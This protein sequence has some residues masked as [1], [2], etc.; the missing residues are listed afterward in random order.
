[1]LKSN[2]GLAI[3]KLAQL[4]T[5]KK[6]LLFLIIENASLATYPDTCAACMMCTTIAYAS[7]ALDSSLILSRVKPTTLKLV[8]T[9][10]LLD[11]QQALKGQ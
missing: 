6:R 2:R 1:M 7:G 5:A 10:F 9:A 8:F 3:V 4:Q 11:A